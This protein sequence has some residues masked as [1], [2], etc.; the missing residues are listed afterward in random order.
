MG[1]VE[2]FEDWKDIEEHEAGTVIF[3]EEDAA[4]AIYLVLS[5]E[6]EVAFRGQ[7][8]SVEG[9]GG[10]LGEMALNPGSNRG[11]RATA[12]TDVRLA[13][14]DREQVKQISEKSPEF[15]LHVMAALASR[16]RAVDDYIG[17]QL[18]GRA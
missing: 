16:L 13:R 8:L 4:E 18:V 1:F 12:R 14:M 6:V 15:S 7:T 2:L 17:R 5:G 10:V 3:S 9:E 11:S